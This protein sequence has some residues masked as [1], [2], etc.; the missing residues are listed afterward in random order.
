MVSL[1][2]PHVHALL[3]QGQLRTVRPTHLSSSALYAI[4]VEPSVEAPGDTRR[5]E[6]ACTRR[7]R[8]TA[9]VRTASFAAMVDRK[10]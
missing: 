6:H 8:T 5:F 10:V 7:P 4:I 2:G 1:S 3:R 9:A